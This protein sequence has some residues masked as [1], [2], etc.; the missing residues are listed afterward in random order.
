MKI[1]EF[2]MYKDGGTIEITTNEGIF[3]FDD[4]L[5]SETKDR[6]YDGY[7]KDDNSNL[8]NDSNELESLIIEKLKNYKDDFYQSTIDHFIKK[9]LKN[10]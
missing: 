2:R 8:M 3:C 10:G 9:K 4:R 1:L 7:P 5:F 6:L